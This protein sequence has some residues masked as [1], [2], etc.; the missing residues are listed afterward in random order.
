MALRAA[1]LSVWL[2]EAE[3]GLDLAASMSEGIAKSS[4]VVALVSP[5]YAASA[6]CLFELR[7][8]VAAGK[9]LVTCCVEPGFWRSWLAADGSG[10]RAVAD[11]H[12]LVALARLGTHLFVDLGEASRVHWTSEASVTPAERR[13]LQAPEALPRLLRLVAESRAVLKAAEEAAAL[14]GQQLHQTLRA[15]AQAALEAASAERAAA[16]ARLADVEALAG[17][18]NAEARRKAELARQRH[19]AAVADLAAAPSEADSDAALDHV[20]AC[21]ASLRAAKAEEKRTGD[22]EALRVAEAHAALAACARA[23]EEA[24]DALTAAAARR[25]ES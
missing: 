23:R 20:N 2:D 25:E 19:A 11:G 21:H 14:R 13:T 1:G 12:E 18:R 8:A 10:A 15:R 3:M 16:A 17:R 9:P 24:A 6:N 4:V 5:D 22:A 7:S